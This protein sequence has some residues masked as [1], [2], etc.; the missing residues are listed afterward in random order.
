M[1]KK[2]IGLFAVLILAS[3]VSASGL[4]SAQT[5]ICNI[6]GDVYNL[7]LY[8]AT[9][10]AAVMIVLMGILWIASANNAKARAGATAGVV[11]AL[12]GLI[13][14]AMAITLVSMVEASGC[15]IGW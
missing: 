7:L 10:V 6:L 5:T 8:I 15:Y 1:N 14:V 9:G 3:V 11:N 13:I 4:A 12:I 2:L